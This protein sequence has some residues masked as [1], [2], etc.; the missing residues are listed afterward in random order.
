MVRV[1]QG[2]CPGSN[3]WTMTPHGTLTGVHMTHILSSFAHQN[4]TEPSSVYAATLIS[5]WQQCT[6][7]RWEPTRSPHDIASRTRTTR[8]LRIAL[9]DR[10][11]QGRRSVCVA[12]DIWG[13]LLH[14]KEHRIGNTS[15]SLFVESDLRGHCHGDDFAVVA[16]RERTL[17]RI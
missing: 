16:A 13:D 9:Q 6:L 10:A 17:R 12:S 15:S 4:K 11:R 14:N 5:L 2:K 3:T 8:L 1:L 7:L